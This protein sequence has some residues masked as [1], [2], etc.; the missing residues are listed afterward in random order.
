MGLGESILEFV[1]QTK[2]VARLPV[3]GEPRVLHLN[4]RARRFLRHLVR[5]VLPLADD[6]LQVHAYD[7]LEQQTAVRFDVIAE[8]ACPRPAEQLLEH[9]FSLEQRQD[10][11]I[12]AVQVQQVERDVDALPLAQQKIPESFTNWP[13]HYQ[14][15]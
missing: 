12:L 3:P 5:R 2:S 11:E 4:P 13:Q 1:A 10:S 7:L 6:A 9:R 15:P 8:N 14:R